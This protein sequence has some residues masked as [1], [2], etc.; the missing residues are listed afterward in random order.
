MRGDTHA[1]TLIELL[2]VV[3]IIVIL[4]ALL[5]P[6][7]DKAM[8]QAELVICGARLDALSGAVTTYAFD[9]NRRYPHRPNVAA[10]RASQMRQ[11]NDTLVNVEERDILRG[12]IPLDLLQCPLSPQL[13]LDSIQGTAS[14]VPVLHGSYDLWYGWAYEDSP[15][16]FKL[17]D[18]WGWDRKRFSIVASDMNLFHIGGPHVISSHPDSGGK[19]AAVNRTTY[20]DWRSEQVAL[21]RGTIDQNC[22]FS[23][24]SVVRYPDVKMLDDGG[25]RAAVPWASHNGGVQAAGWQLW[26]PNP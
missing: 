17:G 23:D 21:A 22:L 24:G 8:Y 2:V 4:L 6:V 9:F 14:I 10:K 25:R 7:L 19:L 13:D 18:R 20:A 26:V 1:F 12:R 16:M 15:G 11:L 3:T 5:T